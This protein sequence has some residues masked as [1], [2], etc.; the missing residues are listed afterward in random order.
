MAAEQEERGVHP[1]RASAV[2]EQ[3]FHLRKID[4]Y[5]V[6]INGI[7]I[8]VAGSVKDRRAGMEHDRNSVRFSSAI[9]HF[10]FSYAI[11]I[12]IGKQKLVGRMNFDHADFEP[13]KVLDV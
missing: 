13:Q 7:A 1:Q 4:G 2:R 5:I 10:Q 8:A 11:L 3:N 12:A 9:D 6:N